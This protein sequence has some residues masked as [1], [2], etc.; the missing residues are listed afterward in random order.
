MST[1]AV[2]LDYSVVVLLPAAAVVVVVVV[3]AADVAD[4]AAVPV[5]VAILLV[6]KKWVDLVS[7]MDGVVQDLVAER[8]TV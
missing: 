5:V 4:V 1:W 6:G 2:G 8:T 3:V 7:Y